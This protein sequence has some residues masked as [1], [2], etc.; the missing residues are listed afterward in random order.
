MSINDTYILLSIIYRLIQ[1]CLPRESAYPL[2]KL[3]EDIK[4]RTEMGQMMDLNT[5]NQETQDLNYQ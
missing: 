3:F 2:H 4:F 1:D 5:V